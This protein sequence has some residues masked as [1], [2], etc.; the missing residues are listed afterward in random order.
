MFGIFIIYKSKRTNAKLLFIIGLLIL[1]ISF[2]WVPVS[3]DFLSI[4]FTG[5]N[6]AKNPISYGYGCFIAVT[7]VLAIYFCSEL[8]LPEKKWQIT[9]FFLSLA[10]ILEVFL[11]FDSSNS[12]VMVYPDNPGENLIDFHLSPGSP[13]YFLSVILM[14]SAPLYSIIGFLYKFIKSTGIIKKKYLMLFFGTILLAFGAIIDVL[15][16]LSI[17]FV[18]SRSCVIM[19]FI[20]LYLAL[21]E[22]PEKKEKTKPKKEVRVEGDLFR[23]SQYKKENITEEEVSI[24][25]EKKICLVCKGKVGKIMFMCSNCETFYCLNCSQAISNL[26]NACWVCGTPIDESKPSTPFKQVEEE[27]QVEPSEKPQKKP[28]VDKK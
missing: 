21:R 8:I 14:L 12:V 5:E 28:I 26:E 13:A 15:T 19:T 25:K 23:I 11:I 4:L 2:G 3:L 1:S 9:S 10:I 18:L 24:S 27:I 22:E 6:L 20:L 17:L 7:T 16:T